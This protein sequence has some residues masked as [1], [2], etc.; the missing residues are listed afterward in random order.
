MSHQV[1]HT[2]TCNFSAVSHKHLNFYHYNHF[3]IYPWRTGQAGNFHSY[4]PLTC[5]KSANVIILQ[6]SCMH[7]CKTYLECFHLFFLVVTSPSIKISNPHDSSFL[8]PSVV[9]SCFSAIMGKDKI[10]VYSKY[11]QHK[12]V[13]HSVFIK[14]AIQVPKCKWSE[15]AFNIFVHIWY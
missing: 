15:R 1:T 14:L 10:W 12:C 4:G 7:V 3:K 6:S 9:P 2:G 13:T 8:H 5:N 11:I